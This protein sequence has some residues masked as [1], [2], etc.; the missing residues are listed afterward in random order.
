MGSEDLLRGA[1]APFGEIRTCKIPVDPKSGKPR[2]FGFVEFEEA[3]DAEQ[4]IDNMHES[5][6]FGRTLTVNKSRAQG[7]NPKTNTKPVW[8]DDFF[9]KRQLAAQGLKV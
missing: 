8:A 3:E 5:E 2:G 7:S 9:Y 6:F 4:A 1:F